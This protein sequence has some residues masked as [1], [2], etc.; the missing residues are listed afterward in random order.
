MKPSYAQLLSLLFH[1][2]S[3]ALPFTGNGHTLSRRDGLEIVSTT[4]HSDGSVIDWIPLHS[5]VAGGKIASPPP[6]PPDTPSMANQST[7]QPYS[8]LQSQGAEQGPEGTVPIL[9]QTSNTALVKGPPVDP[10]HMP[11][12]N[13][14]A[15]GDHWYA[16][17]AQGVNNLGGSA[18]FSLYTAWTEAGS[19]FSLLQSAV[20]R[21]NVPK[22]GDNSQLVA[23]TVEAGWYTRLPSSNKSSN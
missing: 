5:Q 7:L 4:A 20:I 15:A 17:S 13:T 18:S 8:M 3:T 16:S 11:D 1:G 19:D 12:L 6:I 22:P 21:Y 10:A 9:R 23:Q 2:L 14:E